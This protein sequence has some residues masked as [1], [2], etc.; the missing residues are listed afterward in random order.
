MKSKEETPNHAV[1]NPDN[2]LHASDG[3][4]DATLRIHQ[5]GG[6]KKRSLPHLSGTEDGTDVVVPI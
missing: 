2:S 6:K 4:N 1:V 5:K 3:C